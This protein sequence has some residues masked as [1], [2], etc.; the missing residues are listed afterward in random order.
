MT[1][2]ANTASLPET[3]SEKHH[4]GAAV[5][6]TFPGRRYHATPWN[7][8]VNEGL[9]E[10]PPSPW[11]V[12]RALLATGYAKLHWSAGGPPQVAVTLLEKLASVLPRYRLP[13]AVG[14]HSRHYMPM[15]RFDKGREQTTLV[16]DTW[17]HIDGDWLGIYWDVELSEEERSLL[18]ELIQALNYLGR[19]E[20]WVEGE[21]I[22]PTSEEFTVAPSERR[23]GSNWEQVSLLAPETPSQY[24]SWRETS[25][26][27]QRAKLP[28]Q[29][30]KGKALTKAQL[31]KQIEEL[32]RAYPKD[33]VACL[34]VDTRFLH[35]LGWSQ[36]PGT[37]KAFYWRPA[38]SLSP[39]PSR[40]D[41]DVRSVP[42]S[43]EF[44]LLALAAESNNTGN[45]PPK[46]RTLPQG[47]LLHRAILSKFPNGGAP[48]VL[49]GR[50]AEG[51]PLRGVEGHRHLH[52]LHLDLD[53]DEHLD[54]VL[55]WAPMELDGNCQ[56]ALRAIRHEVAKTA[57]RPHRVAIAA[58]GGRSNILRIHSDFKPTLATGLRR[59]IGGEHGSTEWVSITPFVPPRFTKPSGKNS[60][61]GQVRAELAARGLPEP[62]SVEILEPN[63]GSTDDRE[64]AR[65]A[66]HFVRRRPKKP[67]P[68]DFGVMMKLRFATPVYGPL[69]LGYGCHFGL[70]A[71]EATPQPSTNYEALATTDLA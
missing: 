43:V 27:D 18:G 12:L 35:E 34:Q 21:L 71:F 22:D 70:G 65:R 23:P 13:N 1:A 45:L 53:G 20:S 26:R 52:I 60:L 46:T 5:K 56:N 40:I 68:V 25:V 59:I 51:R 66:R 30:S 42:A 55:L 2:Q 39:S 17:A 41:R 49:R 31:T 48:D 6:I 38:N 63:R 36:P 4:S 44:V 3:S 24:I 19:S 37:R 50:D 14:T 32:E 47:E 61:E 9:I 28:T 64:L 10:W 67:P 58:T 54:H 69:I 62:D 16:L 57:K 15:A 8:H 29:N 33:L 11:R 7:H